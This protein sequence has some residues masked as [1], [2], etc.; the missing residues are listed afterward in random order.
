[1]ERG[2]YA[3]IITNKNKTTLYIGVT[4]SLFERIYEHKNK[5]YPKSF[6]A[7]YNLSYLIYYEGFQAIEEAIAREKYLKGKSRKFKE[8]LINSFNP[9]WRD[10]TED[11][12]SFDF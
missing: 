6:S 8:D 10:L 12:E 9:S 7:R 2:G 1:M 3:Y 11:T 4:S 5:I